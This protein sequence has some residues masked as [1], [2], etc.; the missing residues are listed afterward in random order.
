MEDLFNRIMTRFGQIRCSALIKRQPITDLCDLQSNYL[1]SECPQSILRSA[2]LWLKRHDRK[3]AASG[4]WILDVTPC[5]LGLTAASV[6]DAQESCRGFGWLH[7][8]MSFSCMPVFGQ[9]IISQFLSV[10]C[11]V[12]LVIMTGDKM[13]RCWNVPRLRLTEQELWARWRF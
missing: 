9:E 4:R 10:S 5:Q 2:I 8:G 13:D 12:G 3:L 7:F 6:I 11:I 1:P